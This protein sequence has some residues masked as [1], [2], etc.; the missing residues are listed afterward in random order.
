MMCVLLTLLAISYVFIQFS[1]CT[2]VRCRCA[3]LYVHGTAVFAMSSH[4]VQM[5]LVE[6]Y[7]A[8]AFCFK[9]L[10][11][12]FSFSIQGFL[13]SIFKVFISFSYVNQNTVKNNC[14]Q[15]LLQKMQS[16]ML[17]N[18]CDER[19]WNVDVTGSLCEY[20]VHCL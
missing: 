3:T 1:S 19:M 4:F 17:R 20:L 12:F 7:H 10:T 8:I 5:S 9:K 2:C 16:L 15:F 18:I 14:I 13:V 6:S 11:D